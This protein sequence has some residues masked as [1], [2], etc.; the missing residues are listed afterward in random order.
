MSVNIGSAH[1]LRPVSIV[2]SSSLGLILAALLGA[3]LYGQLSLINLL[4]SVTMIVAWI[5]VFVGVLKLSACCVS[6]RPKPVLMADDDLPLYTVIIPLFH[7]AHMLPGLI[8]TLSKVDYPKEK[9]DIIF[10]C[11]AVD[12][13]TAQAAQTVSKPPFR[14]LIVPPVRVG[15]EPQTKPR[16]LNY[17]L[18]RSHGKLVTIYDAEDRPHPQQLKQAASAFAA[19]SDWDALQ[20]P[21]HYFNTRDSKLAAQF[22]LEYAGL[23]QV[24]LPFFDRLQLPF[25]LGGTSN[26]MRRD[27]L[28]AVGGWDAFNVTEDAD[29]AFRLS[30]CGGK[31]GWIPAPTREEAVAR[32]RPWC[33]QR[34]R[35][36]KGFIQTWCVHMNQPFAGGWRRAIMLQ[37]TLGLSLLSIFFFAPV[38]F[39]LGLLALAKML[40]LTSLTI[41]PIYLSA[42]AFSLL[43]SM[44]VSA[45]GAIRAG[46]RHLLWHL[47]LT[48]IYWLLLF[49]PLIQALI[50]MR[51][52]PF[53]WHKT[54]H[55]VTGAP[56]S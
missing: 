1:S 27:A 53:H 42:L 29:L 38:M 50:E 32:L 40:G 22:G 41:P 4:Q 33:R 28:N 24:H 16:A 10:A 47:P 25:P 34:S 2:T 26:H 6:R 19:H 30:A 55:G 8:A 31:I 9:L 17:A 39:A 23:F 52:R 43:S 51:T 3:G 12:P 45:L 56:S 15:G 37:L 5:S 46:Q 13:E 49:P 11:E 54:Q 7:E 20:A 18:A 14:T 48:P 36:L 21:L 44:A 35:W